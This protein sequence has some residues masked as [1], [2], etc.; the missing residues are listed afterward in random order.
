M[1]KRKRFWMRLSILAVIS[2]ALGYTFY[3]NFFAD[4]S[5]ARAGEQAVNFVLEDLEGESIELREL[6]G[7]GVFLNFW[8][9]YCPPCEREMPHM[10]KLY[11][12]YKEQG[13]EIIAVNANEPELT[14]QRFVDRYGLSFPIVIDK[15]LN[16]IDAYGIRPLP[17]TILINEHG[18]IVKVHTGGMTEQ[19]VEEFMELIKPEA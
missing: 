17:T 11:G 12:E 14:V 1:D 2:V 7:K 5:L 13:V 6:E 4:R 8:G 9:T 3:S 19:M 16:V 10:E 18:E 15:G